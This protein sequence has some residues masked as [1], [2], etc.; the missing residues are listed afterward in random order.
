[1]EEQS[2][3]AHT[4]VVFLVEFEGKSSLLSHMSDADNAFPSST[5]PSH[6]HMSPPSFH[7][8]KALLPSH[9]TYL[10]EFR[11][12]AQPEHHLPPLQFLE[13]WLKKPAK[14]MKERGRKG[15][16]SEGDL[17]TRENGAQRIMWYVGYD[18]MC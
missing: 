4:H 3:F 12:K 2:V 17:Y 8:R 15:R 10:F 5:H 11:R 14:M 7:F 9:V 13:T 18:T 6:T 16:K 1:L